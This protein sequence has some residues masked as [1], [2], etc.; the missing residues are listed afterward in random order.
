MQVIREELEASEQQSKAA[1]DE[2][3]Q[4]F[5][6]KDQEIS[7]LKQNME[8]ATLDYEDLNMLCQKQLD[9]IQRLNQVQENSVSAADDLK[10]QLAQAQR[11]TESSS[12]TIADQQREMQTKDDE[13]RA[14][15]DQIKALQEENEKFLKDQS[16][17]EKEN[18][19]IKQDMHMLTSENTDLKRDVENLRDENATLKTEC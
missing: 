15:K 3:R 16:Q 17:T 4:Q 6:E 1:L 14:F 8:S 12:Q 10:L 7:T 19:N 2:L 5:D 18:F 9:E 11:E 13:F